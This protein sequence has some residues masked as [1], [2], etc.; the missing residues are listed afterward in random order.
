MNIFWLPGD[1]SKKELASKLN[2]EKNIHSYKS[3][4]IMIKFIQDTL[5]GLYNM[6]RDQETVNPMMI[7]KYVK[8]LKISNKKWISFINYYK[9]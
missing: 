9:S 3:G 4:S 6:T 5:T 8:K 1:D 2:I 7:E